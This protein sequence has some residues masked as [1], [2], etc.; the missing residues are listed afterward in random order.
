MTISIAI[1]SHQCLIQASFL[2]TIVADKVDFRF[3]LSTL[4]ILG[5]NEV[6]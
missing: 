4:T 3:Q 2:V 6:F 1:Y 5:N